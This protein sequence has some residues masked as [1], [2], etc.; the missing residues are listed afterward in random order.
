MKKYKPRHI[1]I[2]D[3]VIILAGNHRG[4][5]GTILSINP[6]KD[7]L[8]V[9]SV[10][11]RIIS[12]KNALDVFLKMQIQ[13]PINISNVMLWDEKANRG[14]TVKYKVLENKKVR[15]FRISENTVNGDVSKMTQGTRKPFFHSENQAIDYQK[16]NGKE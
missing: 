12:K 2:G 9:D 7:T 14:D 5:I 1:R 16:D 15:F 11:P 6:K 4:L 13:K 8:I 10:L 3:K